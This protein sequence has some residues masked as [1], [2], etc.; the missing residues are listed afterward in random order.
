MALLS[1]V[2]C[3]SNA[4]TAFTIEFN[5]VRDKTRNFQ[6]KQSLTPCVVWEGKDTKYAIELNLNLQFIPQSRSYIKPFIV[7]IVN[8]AMILLNPRG[9]GSDTY[10]PLSLPRNIRW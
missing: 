4:K 7:Q 6:G 2:D 5:V 9:H 10:T 8:K 1:G 3:I